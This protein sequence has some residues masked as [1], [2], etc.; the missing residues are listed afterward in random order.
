MFK[1]FTKT[2][3]LMTLPIAS[4]LILSGCKEEATAAP[5]AQPVDLS[6]AGDLFSQP[7]KPNPLTTDP[8]NVVVRVN[9]ENIYRG[10]ITEAVAATLKQYAGRVPPQQLQQLQGQIYNNVKDQL[11]TKKLMDAAVAAAKLTVPDAEVTAEIEKIRESI[12]TNPNA[13]AG[14]TLESA[15]AASGTTLEKLTASIKEQLTIKLFL[16]GKT[17]DIV[18]ATEAEA[19]EFYDSNPDR[20]K[21]PENV[22]ASHILIKFEDTDTDET[23][24]KKKTDLEKI[25]KDIIAGTVTFE[26]AAKAH[27]DCP[28]KAQGGSLGTFGKGQMVPEFEVAAFSQ[29][30][31]EIG[32]IVETKFGYHVIKVS[33]HQEESIVK[34]EEVKDKIIDVLTTQKKQETINAFIKSLRDNAKIELV[35]P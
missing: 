9:G 19:K 13:P 1:K 15:L 33:A 23:K 17:K 20:F 32:E 18:D 24:A 3:V 5:A 29:E 25:R 10:E 2:T 16:E 27:S 4:L 31:G 7:M 11:I 35:S 6:K 22:T 8:S 21:K 30:N 34:F 14:Q 28:S 12:K 26:D